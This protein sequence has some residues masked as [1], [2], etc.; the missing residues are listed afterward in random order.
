MD[1]KTNRALG[2]L[3]KSITKGNADAIRE[4]Y[5]ILHRPIIAVTKTHIVH[6]EDIFDAIQESLLK[7]VTRA[8][9]FRRNDSAYT[10]I[11]TIVKN[12][13]IDFQRGTFRRERIEFKEIESTYE[14]DDNDI[15]VREIF[16]LCSPEERDLLYY[17]F[18][19]SMSFGE[20]EKVLHIPK[21]TVKYR[22]DMLV[23]RLQEHYEK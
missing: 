13:A 3:I 6:A 5:E 20:M 7:I 9:L 11:M 17:R 15:F 1:E 19:L 22:C 8:E 16:A 12:T 21:S 23:K 4:I 14:L 2:K 18:L 10:W